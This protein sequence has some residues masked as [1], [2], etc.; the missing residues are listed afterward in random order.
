MELND[1]DKKKI[2]N[3]PISCRRNCHIF[4][5]KLENEKSRVRMQKF[6]LDN[7]FQAGPHYAS[8]HSSSL[9]LK[10]LS[11]IIYKA[12]EFS[13]VL[14][15]PL[16]NNKSLNDTLYILLNIENSFKGDF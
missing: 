9:G 8:P 5:I 2:L 7:G 3:V 13:R 10:M 14:R 16:H 12:K 11:S 1:F 4:Y 6:L 15:L